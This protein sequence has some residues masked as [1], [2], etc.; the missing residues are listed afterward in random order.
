MDISYTL[1]Y[2]L[3]DGDALEF[4][5]SALLKASS[6]AYVTVEAVFEV[7]K[8]TA[9]AINKVEDLIINV[10]NQLNNTDG[11]TSGEKPYDTDDPLVGKPPEAGSDAVTLD[12][13]VKAAQAALAGEELTIYVELDDF[14][15][16][17]ESGEYITDEYGNLKP[18]ITTIT[19]IVYDKDEIVKA[20]QKL[21][22][23][24]DTAKAAEI[25][26]YV[27]SVITLSSR[28]ERDKDWKSVTIV[29]AGV[30]KITISGANGGHAWSQ[31]GKMEFGGK[32]G[33]VVAQKQFAAGDVLKIRIGT[34]GKGMAVLNDKGD[35][36][37]RDLS[38][39]MTANQPGGW[40]NGGQGGKPTGR[41]G[42]VSTPGSGG[43][44]ATDVYYAGSRAE[45][46]AALKAPGAKGEL[47]A[48]TRAGD[49]R[50][51][52][53]GGG[54]AGSIPSIGNTG[55]AGRSTLPG[56]NAGSGENDRAAET[57]A[58]PARRVGPRTTKE[59]SYNLG[60]A[61]KTPYANITAKDYNRVK[62]T[63]TDYWYGEYARNEDVGYDTVPTG[64]GIAGRDGLLTSG[65]VAAWEGSGGGGGGYY[66][67]NAIRAD[68]AG[69]SGA[70]GGGSNYIHSDFTS[71]NK[72][73]DTSAS[74]GNGSFKIEF[75]SE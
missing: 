53:G 2:E 11:N 67:G 63:N 45:G 41:S 72:T 52:A 70:G 64:Q 66:G 21:Q 14:E 24:I 12:E 42:Y 16:D 57:G 58:I 75:I 40:P 4:P 33:Y 71:N 74:Y 61:L 48:L 50:L 8:D 28:E 65:D 38:V 68:I 37:I 25:G 49:L 62:S 7:D 29:D 44:G 10:Q 30:Y 34:E 56:G 55:D 22:E 32:G 59:K 6:T 54:G 69:A 36:L 51:V 31:S 18:L 15:R 46:G 1:T 13:A 17:A 3:K 35:D 27:S 19:Y 47:G 60:S 26:A 20:G 39:T 73:N 9:A 5:A 43:G 23:A